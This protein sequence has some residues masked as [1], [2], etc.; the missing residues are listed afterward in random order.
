MYFDALSSGVPLVGDFIVV[1]RH[2]KCPAKVEL[3]DFFIDL[4]IIE[5]ELLNVARWCDE[6]LVDD[7]TVGPESSGFCSEEDLT[8]FTLRWG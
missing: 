4:N 3:Y 2:A 8:A 1:M 5:R 6:N 7:W